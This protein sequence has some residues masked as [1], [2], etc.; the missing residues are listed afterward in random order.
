MKKT[1]SLSLILLFMFNLTGCKKT[2]E[3]KEENSS[4]ESKL[5]TN[6]HAPQVGSPLNPNEISG[7]FTKFNFATGKITNDDNDWDIAFR[8]TTII[9]NGGELVGYTDEPNKTGQAAAYIATG[10]L[11]DITEIETNLLMQDKQGAPAI[12]TGSGNGWYIYDHATYTVSPI[13]GRVLVFR[14]HDGKYAKMEI[15]SYYK[16]APKNPDPMKDESK[17]YTFKYVYQPQA[18]VTS[19]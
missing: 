13:P 9:V 17:Y 7:A 2:K 14:T 8:A 19:F 11:D 5:I 15:L 16:D 3:E 6:L 18:G 4:L 10:T 1:I 12:P